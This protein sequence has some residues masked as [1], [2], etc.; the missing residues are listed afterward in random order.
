MSVLSR[1]GYN[2]NSRDKVIDVLSN[3]AQNPEKIDDKAGCAANTDIPSD[4]TLIAGGKKE[5]TEDG[6]DG[7]LLLGTL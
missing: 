7:K 4:L 3:V 5:S 2:S 6:D 1:T